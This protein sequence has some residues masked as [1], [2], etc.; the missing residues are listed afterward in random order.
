MKKGEES[1]KT[2]KTRQKTFE[3]PNVIQNSNKVIKKKFENCKQLRI[4]HYNTCI[5]DSIKI[6][7]MQK[8][9]RTETPHAQ[10]IELMKEKENDCKTLITQLKERKKKFGGGQMLCKKRKTNRKSKRKSIRKSKRKSKRNYLK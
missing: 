4:N 8:L 5:K 10:R 2:T 6:F 1:K 3:K 9:N 7:E